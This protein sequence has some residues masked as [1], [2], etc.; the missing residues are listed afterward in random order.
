[1]SW[2][3]FGS[4]LI[5]MFVLLAIFVLGYCAIRKESLTDLF[6]E[7]KDMIVGNVKK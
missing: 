4:A 3:D 7:I 6:R 1:M 5:T 2:S